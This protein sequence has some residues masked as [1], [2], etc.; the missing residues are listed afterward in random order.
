MNITIIATGYVST[1]HKVSAVI[2]AE[3]YA[4]FN[5]T[6]ER[7]RVMGAKSAEVTK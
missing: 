3:L 7:A 4:P 1:A 2:L 5:L 6:R